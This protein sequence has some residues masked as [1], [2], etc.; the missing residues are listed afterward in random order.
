M[1]EASC[2]LA[3]H[4]SSP[5]LGLALSN[6]TGETRQQVWEL[7]RDLST[8]LHGK[9]AEFLHPQHW[10]D[11]RFIAVATGPGGF[12]GTR[13]GV[14][15][16]RTLAQQL[17]IPLYGISSLGAIAHHT[18]QTQFPDPDQRPDLAIALPAQRGQLHTAI[19]AWDDGLKMVAGDRVLAPE[20][21]QGILNAYPDPY[22]AMTVEG[23]LGHTAIDLLQLAQADWQRGIQQEWATVLPYY[24]QHPVEKA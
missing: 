5:D 6:A 19:F 13:I 1:A 21:W 12:T 3:I 4:T 23:G 22:H 20:V 18:Y 9:L 15:T 14:V 10:S 24:G 8:Q 17:N 2:A 7:G 11:L 16:A